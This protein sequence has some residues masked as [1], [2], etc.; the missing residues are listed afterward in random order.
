MIFAQHLPRIITAFVLVTLLIIA[1]T[2]GPMALLIGMLIVTGF[3]LWEFYR[4]FW[5]GS[6][7]LC[8]RLLSLVAG[9]AIIYSAS[10]QNPQAVLAC[11]SA[12]A[13]LCAIYFLIR[14]GK[15]PTI[16]LEDTAILLFGIVY[17]PVFLLPIFFFTTFEILLIL[18]AAAASDTLAYFAGLRYG[19]CKIWPAVSPKKSVEGSL[20]GLAA[21]VLATGLMGA[22]FGT[23]PWYYFLLLGFVLNIA[24]QLGDFF[25]SAIKRLNN[26]KDS[27][28]ILP[29]HG[30]VLDRIDSI[31]FLIPT[32]SFAKIFIP[33]F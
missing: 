15:N 18:I 3:A 5:P 17:I 11:F 2:Q 31:L 25:E 16:G 6:K 33:F 14:W 20:A 12:F 13:L 26:A 22:I 4:L 19:R 27:G 23:A 10:W 1:L 9:L 32:Y 28:S 24:A 30:G 8:E 7:M 29:G 21:C